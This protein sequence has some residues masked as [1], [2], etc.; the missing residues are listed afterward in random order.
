M[1]VFYAALMVAAVVTFGVSFLTCLLAA[2]ASTVVAAA[3]VAG[4]SL[5]VGWVASC[6][7]P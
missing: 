4:L 6:R 2:S 3:V 5:V 1:V 7:V